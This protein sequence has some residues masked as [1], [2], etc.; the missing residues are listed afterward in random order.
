MF[1]KVK[2][3]MI[4]TTGYSFVTFFI[5]LLVKYKYK[6]NIYNTYCICNI[7]M[8]LLHIIQMLFRIILYK[9]VCFL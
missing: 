4:L 1:P 6:R 7:Y 3:K 2:N 9:K 5:K 8:E